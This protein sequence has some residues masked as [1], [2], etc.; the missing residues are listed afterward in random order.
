MNLWEC[1]AS[2]RAGQPSLVIMHSQASAYTAACLAADAANSLLLAASVDAR[3]AEST[4]LHP[5]HPDALLVRPRRGLR[6]RGFWLSGSSCS[7]L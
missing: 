4:T 6:L 2:G 3:G 1:R 7:L 5:L